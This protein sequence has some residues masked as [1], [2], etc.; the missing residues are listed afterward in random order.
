M[1]LQSASKFLVDMAE[2]LSGEVGEEVL[3]GNW[4][5]IMEGLLIIYQNDLASEFKGISSQF[6]SD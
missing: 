2:A 4:N 3:K 6:V 5:R 1:G